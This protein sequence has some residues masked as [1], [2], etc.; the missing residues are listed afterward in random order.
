M[1]NFGGKTGF[2]FGSPSSLGSGSSRVFGLPDTANS[3]VTTKAIMSPGSKRKRA[4]TPELPWSSLYRN[5]AASEGVFDTII[6][7]QHHTASS[8]DDHDDE[9]EN[10][11]KKRKIKGILKKHRS[12]SI[13]PPPPSLPSPGAEGGE[14]IEDMDRLSIEN[15]IHSD[16]ARDELPSQPTLGECARM[17]STAPSDDSL[18]QTTGVAVVSVGTSTIPEEADEGDVDVGQPP[19][20]AMAE[21]SSADHAASRPSSRPIKPLPTRRRLRSPPP[22]IIAHD[23]IEEGDEIQLVSDSD[24]GQFLPPPLPFSSVI[25]GSENSNDE[26]DDEED[27][28]SGAKGKFYYKPSPAERWA[29]SQKR[30][31]QIREYK[32][33]ESMEAREKRRRRRGSGSTGG[34]GGGIGVADGKGSL[35]RRVHFSIG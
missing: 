7:A 24:E 22:A 29:R 13:S 28:R 17:M 27:L 5:P 18:Q 16:E 30:L 20:T 1:D 8:V 10:A 19:D 34:G 21:S 6:V 2:T 32:A 9:S 23:D 15:D 14:L 4:S 25:T 31:Q 11:G 33:R 35:R 3:T 12:V 26:D